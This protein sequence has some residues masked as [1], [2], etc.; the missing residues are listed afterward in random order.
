MSKLTSLRSEKRLLDR[1]A[2]DSIRAHIL[3]GILPAGARLLET[4]LARNSRSAAAPC[5]RRSR[6]SRARGW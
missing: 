4:Q 3:D 5:A 6:S 1:Q 2:A